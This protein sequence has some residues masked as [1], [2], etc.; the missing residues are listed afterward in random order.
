ML[1]EIRS[2]SA[3]NCDLFAGVQAAYTQKKQSLLMYL[4]DYLRL[5]IECWLF[6]ERRVGKR[7]GKRVSPLFGE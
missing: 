1:L 7:W 2:G 6:L 3:I 5:L 4:T